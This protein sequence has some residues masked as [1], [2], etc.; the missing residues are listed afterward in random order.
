MFHPQKQESIP[1][2]EDHF[3]FMASTFQKI[4]FCT[5]VIRPTQPTPRRANFSFITQT[6]ITGKTAVAVSVATIYKKI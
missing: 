6:T 1:D 5:H 3:L 4:K 2:E